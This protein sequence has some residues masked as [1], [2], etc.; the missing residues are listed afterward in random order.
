MNIQIENNRIG[1]QNMQEEVFKSHLPK[2]DADIAKQT[3][4]QNGAIFTSNL[5]GNVTDQK[6]Y[7]GQ[8]K[9]KEDIQDEFAVKDVA[10]MQDY[11]T[12]MSNTLSD[13]EYG[14]LWENG[15][16]PGRMPVAE[17]VT[18][19]DEIKAKMAQAGIVITGYNDDLDVAK[20]SEITGS[21]V[22]AQAIAN[23]FETYQVDASEE[24]V[25]ET[26][27]QIVRMQDLQRFPDAAIQYIVANNLSLSLDQLYKAFYSGSVMT[28]EKPQTL[29]QEM[30]AQVD[31]IIEAAGL[32]VNDTTR[33]EAQFMLS[34]GLA[35][36][37]QNLLKVDL[38]RNETFPLDVQ[39]IADATARAICEGNRPAQA[40]VFEKE[41]L[42]EK[43]VRIYDQTQE[44]ND[45]ALEQAVLDKSPVTLKA[46]SG[47]TE[48]KAAMEPSL[49]ANDT[50]LIR[51]KRQLEEIRLQ[52]TVS[53]NY[54]LLKKG[55]E[56]D[57]MPLKDLVEALKKQEQETAQKLFPGQDTT[58]SVD[59]YKTYQSATDIF[60]M[61][62]NLPA[63][64]IGTVD[65]HTTF[66]ELHATGQQFARQYEQL[67]Q[68]YETIGTQ[69][70]GDLGDHI[71]KA[72]RNVDEVLANANVEV[73]Q[74]NERAVRILSYNQMDVTA[75]AIARVREA[76]QTVRELLSQ[77]TPGRTLQMIRDGV[78]PL[79]TDFASLK[80]YLDSQESELSALTKETEQYGKFIYNLE[81]NGQM[82]AEEKD[83]IIG[84]YR[85]IHQIEK[86]DG[87][88]I[89]ATVASGQELNFENLLK[90]ART[91]KGGRFD[92]AVADVDLTNQPAGGYRNSISKQI[93]TFFDSYQD[94]Q[95][96]KAYQEEMAKIIRE[97]TSVTQEVLDQL[98]LHQIPVT[99][100]ALLAQK[101]LSDAKENVFARLK[102]H[103]AEEKI[104]KA[105][106]KFIDSLEDME[107]AQD[108]YEDVQ[109]A[110]TQ[111]IE[112]VLAQGEAT[113]ID[114]R[115]LVVSC[116]QLSLA[117]SLAKEQAYTVPL[118]IDGTYTAV[119]VTIRHQSDNHGVLEISFAS[120]K[121][122]EVYSQF[123]LQEDEQLRG[124]LSTDKEE[125]LSLLSEKNDLICA[126]ILKES[127]KTADV[128]Y[129]KREKVQSIKESGFQ[130]ATVSDLYKVA[131]GILKSF[132]E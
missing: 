41:L 83:A 45:S 57:I 27:E 46:L 109:E 129:M 14:A 7:N 32:A 114:I 35:L 2:N 123:S 98:M 70:R 12:V 69:V 112:D 1:K 25:K 95:N 18:V 86:A 116:K 36:T 80:E 111:V 48:N 8:G 79:E 24:N 51:A 128:L 85:M 67:S 52:M 30:Q 99:P 17:T 73:T 6:A 9:T 107:N 121:Y 97:A 62:P 77:M 110:T 89:G 124:Y 26:A 104:K 38:L 33:E 118:E 125:A 5:S 3:Q 60:E 93:E 84:I 23:A 53:A 76:D 91:R 96:E 56:I 47:L 22:Y 11:M 87:A 4:A 19:V 131:K 37:Q 58:A 68:R 81:Q 21:D 49:F 39:T 78:N 66:G 115:S 100:D 106:E 44:I 82:T 34:A 10:S 105:G 119:S 94:Q 127:G 113:Y 40:N 126:N 90:A 42:Y 61:L 74:E 103:D 63:R 132:A 43:A 54:Q 31:K 108:A 72:F 59:A 120:E 117:N 50:A 88:A 20:L 15:F 130:K 122:G 16:E 92:K 71:T 13:E 29:P 64:V 28:Q 65:A 75:E 102:K 101:Q 55:M